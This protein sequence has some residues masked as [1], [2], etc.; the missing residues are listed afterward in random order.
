MFTSCMQTI[1]T[2]EIRR[3]RVNLESPLQNR[4]AFAVLNRFEYRNPGKVRTVRTKR[5]KGLHSSGRTV[6]CDQCL[7]K[8]ASAVRDRRRRER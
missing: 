3:L 1:E 2:A 8:A 6:A 4:S 5:E 7:L